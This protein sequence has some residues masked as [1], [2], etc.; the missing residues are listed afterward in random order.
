[1]GP[2][3]NAGLQ[4]WIGLVLGGTHLSLKFMESIVPSYICFS[5]LHHLSLLEGAVSECLSIIMLVGSAKTIQFCSHIM[6]IC[7][8]ID[9]L[10]LCRSSAWWFLWRLTGLEISFKELLVF[11]YPLDFL[12]PPQETR[13]WRPFTSLQHDTQCARHECSLRGFKC[14]FSGG[15]EIS[16]GDECCAC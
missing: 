3:A 8:H 15:K 10:S 16:L 5:S 1:M 11:A 6:V 13:R 14:C 9:T 4:S 12:W 2:W 7:Q